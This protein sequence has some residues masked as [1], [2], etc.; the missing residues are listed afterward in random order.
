MLGVLIRGFLSAG[1]SSLEGF[2]VLGVFIRGVLS[3][4]GLD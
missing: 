2:S 1:G 4:G 3:G